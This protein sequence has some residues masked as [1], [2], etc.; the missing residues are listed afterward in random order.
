MDSIEAKILLPWYRYA[1]NMDKNNALIHDFYQPK[2]NLLIDKIKTEIIYMINYTDINKNITENFN[3]YNIKHYSQF[4]KNIFNYCR[5]K[6]II[7]HSWNKY[8]CV[9]L[10]LIGYQGIPL[11]MCQTIEFNSHQFIV[12]IHT[13]FS[14]QD[15]GVFK[16][17]IIELCELEK[18]GI[19]MISLNMEII[20]QVQKIVDVFFNYSKNIEALSFDTFLIDFTSVSDEFLESIATVMLNEITINNNC[21]LRIGIGA[22]PEISLFSSYLSCLNGYK[23]VKSD[24]SQFFLGEMEL[25]RLPLSVACREALK[26]DG[27][28]TLK[29][30]N[31]VNYDHILLKYGSL[32]L[33]NQH[34]TLTKMYND[35]KK[36]KIEFCIYFNVKIQQIDQLEPHIL[37]A[38]HSL[39]NLLFCKDLLF[40]SLTLTIVLEIS[41]SKLTKNFILDENSALD[42]KLFIFTKIMT[43]LK[44]ELLNIG[45]IIQINITIAKLA[46]SSELSIFK[47]KHL[48]LPHSPSLKGFKRK[49][50]KIESID[51]SQF[52]LTQILCEADSKF[53][54]KIIPAMLQTNKDVFSQRML[55]NL[56][57]TAGAEDILLQF[58]QMG[59][60]EPVYNFINKCK[61]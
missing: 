51:K 29:E 55:S 2:L 54:K 33:A 12:V 14:A 15:K 28:L 45:K 11:V 31:V 19:S 43:A 18:L 60:I 39:E 21:F 10:D 49:R 26:N 9:V 47:A 6:S 5:L 25:S 34:N 52:T 32:Y 7:N 58:I 17:Q 24:C 41:P 8:A 16:G 27:I 59:H 61:R 1:L 50:K 30:L 13:S 36:T 40:K 38:S 48:L 35:C 44:S 23:V 37:F 42:G 56:N 57:Y 3:N 22:S 4:D 53:S 20:P 46:F